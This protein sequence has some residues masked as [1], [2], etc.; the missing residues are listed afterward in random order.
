MHSREGCQ[1]QPGDTA[2]DVAGD[3]HSA[4]VQV[5]LHWSK[6]FQFLLGTGAHQSLAEWVPLVVIH[7]QS[8]PSR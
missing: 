2:P 4:L 3:L 7:H 6:A 5:P 1:I 8:S